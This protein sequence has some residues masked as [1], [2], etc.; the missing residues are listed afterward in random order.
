MDLFSKQSTYS[1][2]GLLHNS[3]GTH[4][5]SPEGRSPRPFASGGW[6]V[7]GGGW[8]V[9]GGGWAIVY[10]STHMSHPVTQYIGTNLLNNTMAFRLYPESTVEQ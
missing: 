6:R 10:E 8:W 7:A 5:K 4:I 2:S 3:V 9:A 1:R